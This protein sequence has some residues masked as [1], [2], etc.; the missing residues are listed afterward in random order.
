MGLKNLL[1]KQATYIKHQSDSYPSIIKQGDGDAL[2]QKF[3]ETRTVQDIKTLYG[4]DAEIYTAILFIN[5]L[6]NLKT[7][8]LQMGKKY[9]PSSFSVALITM[10]LRT[11]N[12]K[13]FEFFRRKNLLVFQQSSRKIDI[14]DHYNIF[15]HANA[16]PSVNI[17]Q[18]LITSKKMD[19]VLNSLRGFLFKD[20][21]Q[22]LAF[23]KVYNIDQLANVPNFKWFYLGQTNGITLHLKR[24]DKEILCL[25]ITFDIPFVLPLGKFTKGSFHN[26]LVRT[27]NSFRAGY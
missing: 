27:L 8:S 24:I 11:V 21:P 14:D 18:N 3:L 23:D 17:Y 2:W 7:N 15:L 6:Q 1:D 25:K 4:K 13:L 9:E 20:F 22:P 26:F 16:L 10:L 12:T 19:Q 5:Y